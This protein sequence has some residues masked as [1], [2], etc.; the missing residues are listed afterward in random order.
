MKQFS[1]SGFRGFSVIWFGQL[2]S[3]L[4]TGTTRF[5]L[6]IWV[7]QETDSVTALTLVAFFAFVPIV[8][9][10]PIAGVFV[11]R[12]N[13]KLVVLLSDLMAGVSTIFLLL[14]V[15][16]GDLQLWHIYLAVAVAG[17]FEAF[18]FPAFYLLVF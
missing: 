9:A 16:V 6:T 2:I 12:W 17:T 3:M 18:Q 4:G 15:F 13:R 11:D 10:S 14:M 8:L 7:F 5:A 1:L